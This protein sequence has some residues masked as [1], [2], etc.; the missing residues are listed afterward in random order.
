MSNADDVSSCPGVV[1]SPRDHDE[2]VTSG[3]KRKAI[4]VTADV[5]VASDEHAC[6][7]ELDGSG[8]KIAIDG[9]TFANFGERSKISDVCREHTFEART[10]LRHVV[11]TDDASS[12]DIDS[13]GVTLKSRDK[14]NS[15]TGASRS[16]FTIDRI[17][18]RQ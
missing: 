18:G 13:P 3:R 1:I 2:P 7:F 8:K 17:L 16:L 10:N 6:K 9:G 11:D 12:D 5:R 4:E 14:H 15:T